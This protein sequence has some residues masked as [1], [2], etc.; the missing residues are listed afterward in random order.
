[1]SRLTF[2]CFAIRLLAVLIAISVF[3]FPGS[4]GAQDSHSELPG[5]HLLITEVYLDCDSEFQTIMIYGDDFLFGGSP[6]VMLGDYTDPL[7][8]IEPASDNQILVGGITVASIRV[9]AH[10]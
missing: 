9:A 8:I 4:V 6:V 5:N 2:N 7:F 1:M 10:W 3:S